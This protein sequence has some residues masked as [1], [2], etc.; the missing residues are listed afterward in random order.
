[1][2]VEGRSFVDTNVLVYPH[3][4][5]DRSKSVRAAGV[6]DELWESRAGIIS[7]QVL[8]EFYNVATRKLDPPMPKSEARDLV[9]VYAHWRVVRVDPIMII[10]AAELEQ[11]ETLSFW[12]AL[13]VEAAQREGAQWLLTED[14][15]DGRSF[16]DLRVR[17][18]FI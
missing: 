17:N 7:T 14:M 5:S 1:M 15:Q 11:E 9:A 6:L 13:I 4:E 3:N 2:A 16:G 18:P 8:I 12:D 10:A